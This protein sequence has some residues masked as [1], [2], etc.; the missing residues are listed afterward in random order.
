MT[1][2]VIAFP[3]VRVTPS[4][5]YEMSIEQCLRLEQAFADAKD[6]DQAAF[7]HKAARLLMIEARLGGKTA[8]DNIVPLRRA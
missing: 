4:S 6:W 1:A 7:F 5:T 8:N 3:H 2:Q